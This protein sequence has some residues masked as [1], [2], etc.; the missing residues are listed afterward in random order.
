MDDYLP[1]IIACGVIVS[2]IILLRVF[3]TFWG[4]VDRKFSGEDLWNVTQDIQISE[5]RDSSVPAAGPAQ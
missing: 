5:L 4:P 2:S 1:V 3:F